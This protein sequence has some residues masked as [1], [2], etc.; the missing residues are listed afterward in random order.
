MARSTN[1]ATAL[2]CAASSGGGIG[3]GQG[4]RAELE[5]ALG[6][7]PQGRPAGDEQLKARQL[8]DQA[9]QI[10]GGIQQVLHVVDDQQ[11]VAARP[12]R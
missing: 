11:H 9:H 5:C 1:S 7:D 6:A 10:A 12:G 4:Q 3:L 8:G 2:A